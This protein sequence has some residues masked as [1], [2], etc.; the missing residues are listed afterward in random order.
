MKKNNNISIGEGV[1]KGTH[2]EVAA[3][4]WTGITSQWK[5]NF[6]DTNI[7]WLGKSTSKSTSKENN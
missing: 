7:L 4:A 6:D 3:P 5:K 2:S 1:G